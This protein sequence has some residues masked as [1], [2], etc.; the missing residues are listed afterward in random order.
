MLGT[1]SATHGLGTR[2]WA[3]RRALLLEPLDHVAYLVALAAATQPWKVRVKVT[4]FKLEVSWSG[5]NFMNMAAIDRLS[6]R[7]VP[8]GHNSSVGPYH[9]TPS[10][11]PWN[12][13]GACI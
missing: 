13:Q 8:P 5:E 7:W 11:S 2:P 12:A 4:H 3:S 9:S 6:I 10:L 1:V